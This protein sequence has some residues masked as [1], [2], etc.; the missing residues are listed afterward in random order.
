MPRFLV[1]AAMVVGLIW[2]I[3]FAKRRRA[4]DL[5]QSSIT[6]YIIGIENALT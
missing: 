5:N 2:D 6:L 1:L 4:F 3:I